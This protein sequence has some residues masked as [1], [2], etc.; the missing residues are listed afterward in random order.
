LP[1][2][3]SRWLSVAAVTEATRK[4]A[5][6]AVTFPEKAN[7]PKNCVIFSGGASRA[8]SERLEACTG[9]ETNPTTI[10]KARNTFSPAEE[11]GAEPG[12]FGATS[13]K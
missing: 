10:A 11:N 5:K 13:M 7:S 12:S 1:T 3:P 4:G 8:K 2:I 6:N 9:A